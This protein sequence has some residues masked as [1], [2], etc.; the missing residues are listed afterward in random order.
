[1]MNANIQEMI[2]ESRKKLVDNQ[3]LDK[4]VL[5]KKINAKGAHE[6]ESYDFRYLSAAAIVWTRIWGDVCDLQD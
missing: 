2:V 4:K 1:M 3:V 5:L 6:R